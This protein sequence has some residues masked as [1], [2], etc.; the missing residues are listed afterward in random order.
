[1][2]R[3]STLQEGAATYNGSAG[4][5]AAEPRRTCGPSRSSPDVSNA[6]AGSQHEV[7]T[8]QNRTSR[9]VRPHPHSVG[10]SL[11]PTKGFRPG[12][13]R[14]TTASAAA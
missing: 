5:D 1:M 4:T 12:A 14:R 6:A 2:A 13:Q 3:P 10:R 7:E 9:Q 11:S 8:I